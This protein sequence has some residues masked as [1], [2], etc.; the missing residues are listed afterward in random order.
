[1]AAT[2]RIVRIR[3]EYNQ[4]VANETLEDYSLRFTAKSSRRWSPFRVAN[5]ALGGISFLALEAIGGAIAINYGFVNSAWAILIVGLIIFLTGLPISYYAARE[6]IDMDL[7]TRGAGFGYIGS[8]ITSLIYASFTFIFFAIEAAIMSLA[9]ELAFDIPLWLGYIVSSLVVIPLVTHGIT[10]ISQF[11]LW[12]QPVWIAL[13]ALPFVFIAWLSPDA[14]SDWTT[15]A[16]RQG[17]GGGGFDLLLFG[18]ASAVVFSL[19]AQIGEQV[20]FLRFLPPPAAGRRGRWWA[21]LLSA[22]P[23]WIV[24][25]VLKMLAGSFLAF[26][27]L[28]HE[29]SIDRASE[30]TQ[31]YLTGFQ[32]VFPSPEAALAVT[33]LFVILSQLKINVTNAYAGSIAWSNFFARLTHIHPGR[34]VWLVFNVAIALMLMELGVFRALEQVLGLYSNVA[35]AWVGALVADLVVNK[36]LG[37]SPRHIEFK[38][39]HLYDV[40]PV[41]VGAML[42]ASLVGIACLSGLLGPVAQALSPFIAF[43]VAF[44]SAPVIAVLTGG[45]YYIARAPRGYGTGRGTVRCII[46]ENA[47]EP[48]DMTRCPAYAGPICSL[49]CSLD[50]RCHDACKPHARL[51]Q[52]ITD[53]LGHTLPAPVARRLDSPLGHYFAV[54]LVLVGMIAVT[55]ALLDYQVTLNASE[56]GTLAHEALWKT[57]FVLVM[58]AGVGAWLFV[59]AQQSRR[60]AEAESNRQTSLLMRE[61]RAHRRTDA[62][63]QRAKEAAE[64]A[65]LAK[66]RYV[67]GISHELR[68]PLNTI[69]GYA[70]LLQRDASVGTKQRDALGIIRRSGE[71][72][73]SLIDGLLDIAR[74]EAGK[75][76]L[77]R[78]EIRFGEFL[79]QLVSMFRLQA[80]AKGL[81]FRYVTEGSLPAVVNGDEKRLQQILINLLSNAIKFTEKGSVTLRVI[82]RRQ[83]ATFEVIDT[84]QGIAA[85]ELDLIFEPFERG[86]T[87][88]GDAIPGTGLGLTISKLL[89]VIMGGQLSVESQPGAGS[90]FRVRL[91]LSTVETPVA[92]ARE[93]RRIV[94]YRGPRLTVL[95]T[96]DEPT[97]RECIAEFLRPIG[98][99][100][101]VADRGETCLALAH[102]H[103]VHVFLL[104]IAMPGMDGW[105][106]ARTLRQGRYEHTPI[107]M[108]SANAFEGLAERHP[109]SLHDDFIV[110]PVAFEQLVE[111]LGN[112][113]HLEWILEGDAS[114]A[115]PAEIRPADTATDTTRVPRELIDTLWTL[116]TMGYV[117][118]IHDQLDAMMDAGGA[119]RSLAERLRPAIKEF[120]LGQY[121][122]A[123]GELREPAD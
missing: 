123:I 37:L 6:G 9:L 32:F 109:G 63:L 94:G 2:Q 66:S 42:L 19:I 67:T 68:T 93:V 5:T 106:L 53:A 49:C 23:G 95:V 76:H 69:L 52:Q 111:K 105:T 100:V 104:D 12:T 90:T 48:E 27:A 92:V 15:F 103:E 61:I 39:A 86:S 83:I 119:Q 107:V 21:A 28:Q 113:L 115:A 41:G 96:D 57:F 82:Y 22:G 13:H 36:P 114:P 81:E 18:A 7:L 108:V 77:H 110:K 74:I 80:E 45:R 16:G 101:L 78:G 73:A 25:G 87:R 65:N 29:T 88:T 121:M 58:F 75:L 46:C 91:M 14:F 8:T 84:G 89:T 40:N 60:V 3:R 70:Q 10:F 79:E 4:W 117:R 62:R 31:M 116:G 120:K 112:L 102:E 47:F 55:I 20:D 56:G 34:V 44:V 85:D 43:A 11:Q 1:M 26:L 118:G 72:L 54:V 59:L 33:A 51:G 35:I 97:H 50:A 24:L 99:D 71:H 98:F 64:A 17:D 122:R 38:R 30:P